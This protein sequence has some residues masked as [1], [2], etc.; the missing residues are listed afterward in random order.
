MGSRAWG[1]AGEGSDTDRR[2]VFALPFPWTTGLAEPPRDLVSA[3]GSTSYWEVEK[4]IRQARS[5]RTLLLITHRLSQIR[6]ADYILVLEQG[7]LA[8]AGTHDELL[9]RSPH[10]RR[11][12]ARY[13]VDLPPLEV[14]E[15]QVV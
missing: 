4:A 7:R 10:Y 1:L 2:G 8:A 9:R 3:D 15:L 13:D 14:E 6:W 11:I 12:F 5:G